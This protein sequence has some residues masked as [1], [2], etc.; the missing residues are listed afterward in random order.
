MYVYSCIYIH[1]LMVYPNES[2]HCLHAKSI[3]GFRLFFV[4]NVFTLSACSNHLKISPHPISGGGG[5]GIGGS[6]K[7]GSGRSPFVTRLQT[8]RNV[9]TQKI[10]KSVSPTL[11]RLSPF[12]QTIHSNSWSTL[13]SEESA[14]TLEPLL[15]EICLQK[16]FEVEQR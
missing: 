1:V 5:R 16:L 2:F 7:H 9:P 14:F 3:L 15:P 11:G 12:Y 6:I 10:S 8:P 4:H 13:F